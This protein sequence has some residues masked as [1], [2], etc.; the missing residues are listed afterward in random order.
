M[1]SVTGFSE[2]HRAE[3]GVSWASSDLEVRGSQG[4]WRNL[5]L[6][7]VKLLAQFSSLHL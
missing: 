7:S 2:Y 4:E 5:F 6:S 1:D 3:I